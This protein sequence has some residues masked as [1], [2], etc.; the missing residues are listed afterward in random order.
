MVRSGVVSVVLRLKA[1]CVKSSLNRSSISSIVL[2]GVLVK[3]GSCSMLND[4]LV[5]D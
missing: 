2:G 1:S 4:D 3:V 5:C